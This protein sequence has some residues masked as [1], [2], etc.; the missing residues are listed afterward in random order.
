MSDAENPQKYGVFILRKDEMNIEVLVTEDFAAAKKEYE[1]LTESWTTS[2]HDSKP[3]SLK[4]P[5]VTSFDPGLIY[6]ITIRPKVEPLQSNPDNPYAK[7]MKEKGLAATRQ[8]SSPVL[9]N[10]YN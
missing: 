9:D 2:L 3:F 5:I 7:N 1:K 6:E 8:F 10:G 4:K